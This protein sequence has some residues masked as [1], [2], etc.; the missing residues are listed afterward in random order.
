MNS[1]QWANITFVYFKYVTFVHI[2][3]INIIKTNKTILIWDSTNVAGMFLPPPAPS[4]WWD[5][6][7]Q[8]SLPPALVRPTQGR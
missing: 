3:Y 7:P 2:K 4:P 1:S 8:V 6:H 5:D